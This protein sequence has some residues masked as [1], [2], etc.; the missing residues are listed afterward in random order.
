MLVQADFE[1]DFWDAVRC[2]ESAG[3][4]WPSDFQV[5]GINDATNDD[6]DDKSSDNGNSSHGGKTSQ[7]KSKR[8]LHVLLSLVYFASFCY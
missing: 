6:N 2:V 4:E 1:P 3:H 7:G 5:K 8:L